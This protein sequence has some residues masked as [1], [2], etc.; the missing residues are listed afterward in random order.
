MQF[1][2]YGRVLEH[3]LSVKV[4]FGRVQVGQGNLGMPIW[5][6]QG[7]LQEVRVKRMDMAH[8]RLK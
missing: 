6:R 1:Q 2:A 3:Y 4:V 7:G 8:T 5:N